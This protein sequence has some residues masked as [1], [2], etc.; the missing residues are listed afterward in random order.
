M[1]ISTKII[2]LG[3]VFVSFSSS[4]NAMPGSGWIH[5]LLSEN[6]HKNSH[7]RYR[8]QEGDIN[9]IVFKSG[10]MRKTSPVS[11]ALNQEQTI[12]RYG[13]KTTKFLLRGGSPL[14]ASFRDENRKN[15]SHLIDMLENNRGKSAPE[16]LLSRMNGNNDGMPGSSTPKKQ[17]I[18]LQLDIL[19]SGSF[20]NNWLQGAF[21]KNGDEAPLKNENTNESASSRRSSDEGVTQKVL[22]EILASSSEQN[23]LK[24]GSKGKE[25]QHLEGDQKEDISEFKDGLKQSKEKNHLK[26]KQT[27]TQNV[28]KMK[29]PSVKKESRSELL[30]PL[31][32]SSLRGLYSNNPLKRVLHQP[33]KTIFFDPHEFDADETPPTSDMSSS[34]EWVRDPSWVIDKDEEEFI[35]EQKK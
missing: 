7:V 13:K 32:Y 6:R 17:T 10:S 29:S 30:T 35:E 23:S 21:E 22:F 27:D 3:S 14:N 16:N 24:T 11:R 19:S 26:N 15:S 28:A 2:I 20:R 1:H 9:T 5:K 18:A 25:K 12:N 4:V 34:G 31:Y 33:S 8:I